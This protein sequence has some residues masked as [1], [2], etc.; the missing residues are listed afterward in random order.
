M[1][2]F[3]EMGLPYPILEALEKANFVTPTPIQEKSIPLALQGK[4]ILGSAK[5]GTGKTLAFMLPLVVNLMDNPGTMAL[6][7]TPTRELAQQIVKM[8]NQLL[9]SKKT[10]I[11]TALLIGGEPIH[12]QLNQLKYGA[13]I[14]IGTPGRVID[15]FARKSVNKDKISFLVLDET[16]R[17]L[18]MGFGLQ[19]EQIIKQIPR[20]R[21]SLLFSATLLPNVEK[22]LAE[23]YLNNPEKIFI[24][25]NVIAPAVNLTQENINAEEKEKYN[26]LNT[27]L[28]QREG[29]IIVFVKT[30]YGADKLAVRLQK[31]DHS[32]AAIH[33]DLRQHKR[34]RV[35]NAFRQGR[36]RIMV[37]TDVAA[38]GIDVPHVQHVINFDLPNAP[39]DY[40]HRIGRTARAGAEGAA[41]NI[42]SPADKKNWLAIDRMLNPDNYKGQPRSGDGN[43]SSRSRNS[44]KFSSKRKRFG[45]NSRRSDNFFESRNADNNN[46]FVKSDRP[47]HSSDSKRFSKPT[48]AKQSDHRSESREYRKSSDSRRSNY[49]NDSD[50]FRRSSDSRPRHSSDKRSRGFNNSRDFTRSRDSDN[51]SEFT[52]FNKPRRSRDSN[53]A[54]RNDSS[55]FRRSSDSKRSS[56]SADSSGEFRRS[57]DSRR[58][59][60]SGDSSGEFRRSSDSRRSSYSGDS[61]GEFRRSSGD[62]PRQS[63]NS[64]QFTRTKRSGEYQEVR[65]PRSNEGKSRFSGQNKRNNNR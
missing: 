53:Q 14:L 30:K 24:D 60:Y 26:I 31:E 45:G 21:Q 56:Y 28:G 27:Q 19:L 23:K 62:K 58:S 63:G 15:H 11:T 12:K 61:S 16:D 29:S 49:S 43:K 38:R 36:V 44:N 42:I 51:A 3:T 18:D 13:R 64:N 41:L 46:D 20:Q 33:G 57:S 10:K 34:E 65:R 59:S 37:A 5:T 4:D 2:N 17:I 50:E 55:E 22:E 32:V 48:E 47:K 54:R 40:V 9:S 52:D 8:A 1:V 7:L 39:E 25:N 35:M 6:V